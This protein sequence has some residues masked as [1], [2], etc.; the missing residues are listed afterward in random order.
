MTVI[1]FIL[2]SGHIVMAGIYSYFLP[3]PIWY[4][5]CFQQAPQLVTIL[6]Q[7]V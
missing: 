5:P 3:L 2:L 6:Y 7:M 1:A 4:F